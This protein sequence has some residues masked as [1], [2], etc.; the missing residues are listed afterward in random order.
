[1]GM[2]Y[3][4][5]KEIDFAAEPRNLRLALATDGFN[6]FGNMSTQYVASASDSS[7]SPTMG[8]C[9]SSKLLYVI[10]HPRSKMSRKGF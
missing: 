9:E 4:D 7:K 5:S 3:F 8:M 1:M 6:P 2:N 10:T